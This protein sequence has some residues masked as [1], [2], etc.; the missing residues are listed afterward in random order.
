[1]RQAEA[2]AAVQVTLGVLLKGKA[3]ALGSPGVRLQG[4]RCPAWG[5]TAEGANA[6]GHLKSSSSP[7]QR[8]DPSPKQQPQLYPGVAFQEETLLEAQTVGPATKA[9]GHGKGQKGLTP[10]SSKR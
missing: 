5:V 8:P 9:G 6:G 7:S 2:L 3:M 10:Q 1:M 4:N